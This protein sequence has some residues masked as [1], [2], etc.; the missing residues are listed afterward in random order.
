MAYEIRRDRSTTAS[1]RWLFLG[2]AEILPNELVEPLIVLV[3][4]PSQLGDNHGAHARVPSTLAL[5]QTLLRR[6]VSK[7]VETF[8]VV[9][10]EVVPSYPRLQPEEVLDPAQLGH[11]ILDQ[12]VAVHYQDLIP[13]EHLEPPVHVRVVKGDGDRP[14]RLVDATV[15][16]YHQ[17]LEAARRLLLLLLLLLLHGSWRAVRHSRG[18]GRVRT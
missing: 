8:R 16:S 1:L 3:E 10:V 12:L 15:R 11:R 4:E 14:V 6:L 2:P 7:A 13:R 9:E 18:G 5:L 17:L